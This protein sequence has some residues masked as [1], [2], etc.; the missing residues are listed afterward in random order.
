M[1]LSVPNKTPNLLNKKA[2][3]NGMCPVNVK[4]YGYQTGHEVY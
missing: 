3:P 4:K 2:F 1:L